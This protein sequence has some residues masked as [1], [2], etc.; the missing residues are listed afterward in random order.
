M[1]LPGI[2]TNVTNFGAFVDVGVHQDGLVHISHLSDEFVSDPHQVIKVGDK[3]KVTVIEIDIPRKRIALSLKTNPF[4]NAMKS[5]T[6]KETT[7]NLKI[8]DSNA[9]DVLLSK[10]GKK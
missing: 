5:K 7:T 8:D 2:I 10:F 4:D 1:K 9:L 6:K 3:V